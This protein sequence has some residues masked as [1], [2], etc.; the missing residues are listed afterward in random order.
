MYLPSPMQVLGKMIGQEGIIVYQGARYKPL[1]A[2]AQVTS[3]F[4]DPIA[5]SLSTRSLAHRR[6][7]Q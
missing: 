6:A 1:P 3:F 2:V 5:T 4:W 7:L